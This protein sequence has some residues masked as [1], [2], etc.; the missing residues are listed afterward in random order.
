MINLFQNT[1]RLHKQNSAGAADLEKIEEIP[2][3][4]PPA[5]PGN[6]SST[7]QCSLSISVD[8]L[9]HQENYS[10]TR[11]SDEEKSRSHCLEL[12]VSLL[13]ELCSRFP[14]IGILLILVISL[15]ITDKFT[16]CCRIQKLRLYT[17]FEMSLESY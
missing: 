8:S 9:L 12:F 1:P 17:L 14:G 10:N 16:G 13:Y 5:S 7:I 2:L 15:G 4:I 6:V 3:R 11:L